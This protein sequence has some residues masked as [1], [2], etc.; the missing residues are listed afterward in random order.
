MRQQINLHQP[1]FSPR[2]QDAFAVAVA[3]TLGIVAVALS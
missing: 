2:A 1:L 3:S